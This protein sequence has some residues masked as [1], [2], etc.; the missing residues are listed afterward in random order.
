MGGFS[1]IFLTPTREVCVSHGK[2]VSL[3]V[4]RGQGTSLGGTA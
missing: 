2:T 1:H 4:V 3:L